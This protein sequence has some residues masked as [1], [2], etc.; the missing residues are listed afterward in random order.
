MVL[1]LSS[2][3]VLVSSQRL[4][5]ATL[6]LI[7]SLTSR[8][9]SR[10][11]DGLSHADKLIVD[12]GSANTW[13]GAN[14]D[15][16]H[17]VT[18]VNL[19]QPVMIPYISTMMD[20]TEYSNTVTLGYGLEIAEQSI[21][22]ALNNPDFQGVDGILGLGPVGLTRGTLQNAQAMIIPTITQN[23]YTQCITSQE[24]ISIFF[25][26]TIAVEPAYSEITFGGTDSMLVHRQNHIHVG[27]FS[28]V[29]NAD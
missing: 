23:L 17:T 11:P 16:E 28:S 18:S 29:I 21:D 4:T 13:I 6:P 1:W 15:Y 2:T 3:G 19:N 5:S 8:E 10:L 26:P 12:T 25:T 9:K 7:V 24:V 14:K 27:C 22:V 20:G